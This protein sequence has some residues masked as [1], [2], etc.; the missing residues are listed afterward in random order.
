MEQGKKIVRFILSIGMLFMILPTIVNANWYVGDTNID[1]YIVTSPDGYAVDDKTTIP[2][3]AEII[4]VCGDGSCG[5][6]YE[7]KNYI[8]SDNNNPKNSSS[9][10]LSDYIFNINELGFNSPLGMD[11]PLLETLDNPIK[12]RLFDSK[13]LY[14]NPSTNSKVIKNVGA[15]NEFNVKYLLNS[16]AGGSMWAY[17]ENEHGW[18]FV[19]DGNIIILNPKPNSIGIIRNGITFD[20]GKITYEDGTTEKVDANTKLN[21][22]YGSF[23]DSYLFKNNQ[24]GKIS[25]YIISEIDDEYKNITLKDDV[26]IHETIKSNSKIIG[27][28][29][30][31]TKITALYSFD[32]ED[33]CWD[34]DDCN[35]LT[36][37]AIY[38]EY[39]GKNGWLFLSEDSYIRENETSITPTTTVPTTTKVIKKENGIEKNLYIIISIVVLISISSGVIIYI[40]NKKQS[41]KENISNDTNTIN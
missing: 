6:V 4:A 9:L 13:K 24:Y 5:I 15:S 36:N 30:K 3:G 25:S 21:N 28:I 26:D 20:K 1:K 7:G 18:I 38:V 17:I 34:H 32:L 31:A 22:I 10:M 23:G 19:E 33:Y 16:I 14:T 8:L 27:S 39:N 11:D 37:G 41:K 40:M 29:K 2:Y 12:I 35:E